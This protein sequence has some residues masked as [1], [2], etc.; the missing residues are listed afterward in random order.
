MINT[1]LNGIFN[2]VIGLVNTILSPIDN[3]IISKIPVL[4]TA[5]NAIGSFLELCTSSIGWVLSCFGLSSSCISL[6]ITYFVFK[7]SV[8]ILFST[9]KLAIKWYNSLK[10]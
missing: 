4:D 1:I 2:L 3:I 9:I 7:L 5:F 8:P 10:I 6:I